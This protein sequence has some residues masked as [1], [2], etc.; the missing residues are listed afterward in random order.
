MAYTLAEALLRDEGEVLIPYQDSLGVWTVGV[1][2]NLQAKPLS[3]H[4]SRVILADDIADAQVAVLRA[5]P[6]SRKLDGPR[7]EALVNMT[8][9]LGIYGLLGFKKALAAIERGDWPAMKRELRDSEWY[10][11]VGARA[12]RI[13][14]QF[15]TG[16]R[17]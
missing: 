4:A 2:H 14:V 1:G 13:I 5:L 10:S 3:Q 12:D 6:W 16:V 11:Q 17:Q 7:F 15:A 8:F 9:N